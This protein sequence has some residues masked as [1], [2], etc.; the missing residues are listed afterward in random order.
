MRLLQRLVTAEEAPLRVASLAQMAGFSRAHLSR[1]CRDLLGESPAEL[2]RRLRLERA[3]TMLANTRLSV[4]EISREA[5]YATP[6]AFS[7]AFRNAFNVLPSD[8][9]RFPPETHE[10]TSPNGVHWRRG[11]K[12][13]EYRVATEAAVPLAVVERCVTRV[14]VERHYGSLR[15]LN[16]AWESFRN[17]LPME[18]ALHPKARYYVVYHVNPWTHPEDELVTD[19][20]IRLPIECQV[21]TG[22]RLL[23]LPSGIYGATQERVPPV[24]RGQTW[25]VMNAMWHS[26]TGSRPLNQPAFEEYSEPPMIGQPKAAR[27]FLGLDIDIGRVEPARPGV[28]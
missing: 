25:Q 10:L 21:P 18:L 26:Q 8:Y 17:R 11:R 6:E 27:L 12:L 20:G 3:A 23:T 22:L 4:L 1:V 28:A 5:G 13:R 19:V 16:E 7:R 9:R 2:E 24:G 15:R 14:A